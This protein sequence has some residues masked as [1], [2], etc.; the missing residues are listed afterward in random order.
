ML[1]KII[2]T[3]ILLLSYFGTSSSI[4]AQSNDTAVKDTT[5][6]TTSK[7]ESIKNVT[8]PAGTKFTILI[9]TALSSDKNATGST[10]S[11][12]ISDDFIFESDTIAKKNS[13]VIGKIVE[14]K[15]GKG[16]GDAEL[17]IQITEI[18]VNKQLTQVVTNPVTVKGG[19]GRKSEAQITAGTV[20][21]VTLKEALVIK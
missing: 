2:F 19:R 4:L 11:A 17:S 18:T 15:S 16:L 10:F 12:V 8:V 1:Y 14:S 5:T 6:Q 20:E 13:Q 3:L 21:T 7:S 9:N